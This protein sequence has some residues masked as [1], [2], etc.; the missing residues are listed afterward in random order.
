MHLTATLVIQVTFGPNMTSLSFHLS[1]SLAASDLIRRPDVVSKGKRPN[2]LV[3]R[4]AHDGNVSPWVRMAENAGAEVRWNPFDQTEEGGCADDLKAFASNLDER[5]ALVAI[6][7]ASN[8]TG[9]INPVKEM[10]R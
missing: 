10:I 8:A 4:M 3:S 1:H 5:T 9:V 6:P 7:Y 2:V